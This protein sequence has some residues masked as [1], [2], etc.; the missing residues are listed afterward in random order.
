MG[1]LNNPIRTR[2]PVATGRRRLHE[3]QV[4]AFDE[5]GDIYR[6]NAESGRAQ[7]RV[8]ST[9]LKEFLARG[10]STRERKGVRETLRKQPL[11]VQ[12]NDEASLVFLQLRKE[13]YKGIYEIDAK[14]YWAQRRNSDLRRIPWELDASRQEWVIVELATGKAILNSQE[15]SPSLP[16]Y[17]SRNLGRLCV[18]QTIRE[19]STQAS[20]RL[21]VYD[22]TTRKRLLSLD[23][24]ESPLDE[25][26][27]AYDLALRETAFKALACD[28]G[29]AR[30]AVSVATAR[31]GEKTR[32]FDL[33]TGG[34]VAKLP[35]RA[36]LLQFS[37][38]AKQLYLVPNEEGLRGALLLVDIASARLVRR[39]DTNLTKILRMC[40]NADRSRV[41]VLGSDELAIFHHQSTRELLRHQLPY[42]ERVRKGQPIYR[43]GR[44]HFFRRARR[45]AALVGRH[46][47]RWA[48]QQLGRNL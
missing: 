19:N 16:L 3:E 34:L 4:V 39:W 5:A 9:E 37:A 27:E 30:L 23:A 31:A 47:N 41:A 44:G 21:D 1:R 29:D 33:T 46:T 8:G 42:R 43:A 25:D 22:T 14:Y 24:A 2:G 48:I 28:A 15:V 36:S 6:W 45:R 7:N 13:D 40:V 17:F 32:V 12:F 10:A 11:L 35:W 20:E 18:S 26:V 38:D